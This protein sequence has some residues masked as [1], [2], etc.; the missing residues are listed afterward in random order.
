MNRLIPIL[1]LCLFAFPATAQDAAFSIYVKPLHD[2]TPEEHEYALISEVAAEFQYALK[3]RGLWG[4]HAKGSQWLVAAREITVSGELMIMLSIS[5]GGPLSASTIE[6]GAEHQIWYAGK[7]QPEDPKEARFVREMMTREI[8]EGM[9]VEFR[10]GVEIGSD[11]SFEQ[12]ER[13]Y[14][15]S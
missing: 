5:R 14:A 6:A 7:P 2:T 10:L 1:L 3:L 4:E 11:V 9:G 15:V 12:L 8:L 13:G